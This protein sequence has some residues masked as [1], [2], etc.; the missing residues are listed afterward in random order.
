MS[1][2]RP[3]TDRHAAELAPG[4]ARGLRRW[5]AAWRRRPR[6][7]G[8]RITRV[9]LWYVLFTVIV[10]VAAT[11][12]GNNALYLVL[13]GMLALLAVSGYL[14]RRNLLRLAV[15]L[16]APAEIFARAPTTLRFVLESRARWTKRWLLL[17]ATD[18]AGRWKLVPQLGPGER[19][20]G[21]IECIF[22][23]RG[24]HRVG[25]LHVAS[26]FPLGLF[27]KG[28][29]YRLDR[30]LLVYPELYAAGEIDPARAGSTGDLSSP[31]AGW[32]H[33]LHTLRGFRP[34]DDPRGIHWKKSA[35]VGQLIY[36]ERAA[37]ETLRLSILFDEATGRPGDSAAREQFERLV[38]E[39][40][41]AA[42]EY[43][44]RGFEVELVTRRRRLP[45]A[46]GARQ[47]QQVLEHLALI[48]P[49]PRRPEPLQPGDPSAY[50]IHLSMAPGSAVAGSAGAA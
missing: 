30:S 40:A 16:S 46:A 17:V 35:R 3:A 14:S 49:A 7:G 42:V 27:R 34:G 26:L 5:W 13:S 31:R 36:Q 39:A 32:G 23:R 37:E 47:R 50:V 43:L 24:R 8:I 41:T 12:T 15:D 4:G 18:P 10:G 48:E 29:R 44:G 11:N 6:P 25:E 19:A 20:E 45:F 9:G 21:A 28:M 1:G 33:E 2:L 38:S 22:P